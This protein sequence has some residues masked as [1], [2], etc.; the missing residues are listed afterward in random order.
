MFC[1]SC[2]IRRCSF[3][4]FVGRKVIS[5]S[6]SSAILKVPLGMILFSV[7]SSLVNTQP[8]P[9]ASYISFQKCSNVSIHKIGLSIQLGCS[10]RAYLPA[11]MLT[12]WWPALPIAKYLEYYP[13]IQVYVCVYIRMYIIYVQMCVYIICTS[14]RILCT[15][16]C[17]YI[18]TSWDLSIS[19]FTELPHSFKWFCVVH[20]GNTL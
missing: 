8:L 2:S 13:C 15:H 17:T 9:S 12:G 6:Y 7:K 19:F 11:S 14:G 20:C 4:V 3:D 1:R 16:F 10:N 18:S 5:T